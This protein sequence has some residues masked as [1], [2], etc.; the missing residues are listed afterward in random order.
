MNLALEI[1]PD[2][3]KELHSKI[4]DNLQPIAKKAKVTTAYV[5]MLLRGLR[6]VTVKNFHIITETQKMIKKMEKE[7]K[8]LM[9]T[10]K[11]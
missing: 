1:H 9:K 6:P 3:L 5:S 2:K 10:L 11:S 8:R 7:K 4:G